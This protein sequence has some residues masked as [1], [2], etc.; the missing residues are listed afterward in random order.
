[1]G[2]PS[3][4]IKIEP[5]KHPGLYQRLGPMW[6]PNYLFCSTCGKQFGLIEA[7]IILWSQSR[8]RGGG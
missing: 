1:M 3:H 2:A 8:S 5:C 6:D 4:T 7:V